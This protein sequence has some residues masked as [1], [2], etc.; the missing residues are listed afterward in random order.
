M[1]Q[2]IIIYTLR[3][4]ISQAIIALMMSMIPFFYYGLTGPNLLFSSE[5]FRYFNYASKAM[6]GLVPYRDYMI[7]YPV[8]A[9]PL[10]LIPRLFVAG[11][12][13]YRLLFGIEMLLINAAAVYLVACYVRLK[14]GIEQVP[15][16]LVWYTLFFL[17]LSPLLIARFD[18]APMTFAFAAAFWWFTGRNNFGGM[19]AGIGTLIK[20][21]PAAVALPAILWEASRSGLSRVQGARAFILSIVAGTT[22]WI[23]LGGTHVTEF[24]RYHLG[25]GLEIGSVYSGI[26]IVIGKLTG[27][28]ISHIFTHFSYELVAP[29]SAQMASVTLPIQG[30][31]LLFVLWQFRRSKMRDGIRYAAAA[32][33][34]FVVTGKV[35][36]PQFVIWLF[37]FMAVLEGR[38]GAVARPLFL[39]CCLS[40]TAIYPWTFKELLSFDPWAVGL[41][42]LRNFLLLG[43]LAL[44][45]FGPEAPPGTGPTTL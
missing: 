32:V 14:E 12:A 23:I 10:F 34:A 20:I 19:T 40:T 36:S 3:A 38:T 26:L 42:N 9:L 22:F 44:L 43:L 8:F 33:L 45:L 13:G 11:W 4:A 37:P 31:V 1:K 5:V 30:A 7:E 15:A 27:A 17:S 18:L 28:E 24:I 41:L 35:L 39:F 6:N 25:R 16:R 21:F 2:K 29:W